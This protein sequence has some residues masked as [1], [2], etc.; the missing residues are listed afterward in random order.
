MYNDVIKRLLKEYEERGNEPLSPKETIADT[1][2]LL[3]WT[4]IGCCG[5]E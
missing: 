4:H 5:L 2:L 3:P 1:D